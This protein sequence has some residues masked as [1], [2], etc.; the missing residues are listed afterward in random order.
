MFLSDSLCLAQIRKNLHKLNKT[1]KIHQ[2]SALW[3]MIAIIWFQICSMLTLWGWKP[4]A[5]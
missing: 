5:G 3:A 1:K 4:Q 2:E